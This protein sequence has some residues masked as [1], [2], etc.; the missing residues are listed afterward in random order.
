MNNF[1]AFRLPLSSIESPSLSTLLSAFRKTGLERQQI[2]RCQTLNN[3][4]CY[5][6]PEKQSP[7]AYEQS[8]PCPDFDFDTIV[9]VLRRNRHG[10]RMS[11]NRDIQ[12]ISI[13]RMLRSSLLC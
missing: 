3:G 5:N 4:I 12:V 9:I 6:P 8:L 10:F 11:G 7:V 13:S 2:S 1:D